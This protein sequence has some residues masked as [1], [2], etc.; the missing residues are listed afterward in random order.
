MRVRRKPA[1]AA[2][3]LAIA[4]VAAAAFVPT[5]ARADD[6]EVK[7]N[8]VHFNRQIVACP[9]PI[10]VDDSALGWK[11]TLEQSIEMLNR[12]DDAVRLCKFLG[13]CEP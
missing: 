2:R 11:P 5:G 4:A 13:I 7:V 6:I 10:R 8:C 12:E 9:E 3:F 1:A